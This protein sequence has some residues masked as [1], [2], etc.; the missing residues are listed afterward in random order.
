MRTLPQTL[1]ALLACI[2]FTSPAFAAEI[3]NTPSMGM[4]GKHTFNATPSSNGATIRWSVDR[5]TR[6]ETDGSGESVKANVYSATGPTAVFNLD[7]VSG[8]QTIWRIRASDS[9]VTD[10]QE[11]Q[12]FS[13]GRLSSFTFA[14]LGNP[15][16]RVY[17]AVP[18]KL[19][20]DS[21]MLFVMHGAER[22]AND[23]CNYWLKWATSNNVLLLCPRFTETDWPGGAGYNRGRVFEDEESTQLNPESKWAF[24]VVELLQ[25]YSRTGFGLKDAQFDMWGHSAGGQFVERF[26]LFKPNAKLRLAMPAN[27]GWYMMPSM[28][29]DYPCG[30]KS[31]LLGFTKT[32]LLDFSE[33]KAVL[34]AGTKDTNPRGP[35]TGGCMDAQGEGRYAR[36]GTFY[37]AVQ[38]L[39]PLTT[40]K[41]IDVLGVDHDP[42]RMARAAQNW[43]DEQAQQAGQP[44][45]T[46]RHL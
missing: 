13:G 35:D 3:T 33:R 18:T 7:K 16:I 20:E 31:S 10:T 39:N 45:L 14:T 23:N 15:L 17:V 29:T 25:K 41:K 1:A 27:P 2:A 43:L 28:L 37:A 21:K 11:F 38:I 5:V 12:V 26:L 40:W 6:S 4:T 8:K 22:A 19:T 44:V 34:F 42:E 36:A 46:Q 32:K 24:T 30:A 9:G